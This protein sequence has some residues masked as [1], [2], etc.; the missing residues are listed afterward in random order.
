MSNRLLLGD[1][2]PWPAQHKTKGNLEV[3]RSYEY[4]RQFAF[5]SISPL[6]YILTDKLAGGIVSSYSQFLWAAQHCHCVST[7]G[8]AAA[9]SVSTSF[10]NPDI[11]GSMHTWG[12]VVGAWPHSGFKHLISPFVKSCRTTISHNIQ[13]LPKINVSG[14][15]IIIVIYYKHLE[16]RRW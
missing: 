10:W 9:T 3:V 16:W 15:S 5:Q 13:M 2:F 1:L 14:H 8:T 11:T 7:D 6:N 12:G 4:V